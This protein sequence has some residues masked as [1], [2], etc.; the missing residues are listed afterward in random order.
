M[1]ADEITGLLSILEDARREYDRAPQDRDGNKN[2]HATLRL[3]SAWEDFCR[4]VQQEGGN[5]LLT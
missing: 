1:N 5:K 4:A 3:E 2:E